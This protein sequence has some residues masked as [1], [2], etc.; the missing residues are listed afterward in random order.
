MTAMIDFLDK[1]NRK[2]R[3]FLIGMALGKRAFTLG[4]SFRQELC[5]AFRI[6][7]P[8]NA[9]V[10]MDYHLNCIHAAAALT[11]GNLPLDAPH[12][13]KDGSVDGTQE[14]VDLLVAFE[15]SSA[16]VHL[17]MLEAKGVT[18]FKDKQFKHKISRFKQIFGHT[19]N[20]WN[21]VK[22]YL[23]LIS[24]KKPENLNKFCPEWLKIN[25][26][27]AWLPMLIPEDRLVVFRCDPQ[28]RQNKEG[29]SWAVRGSL[30]W[31]SQRK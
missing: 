8:E 28:R 24:P 16:I 17:I 23:G 18:P 10:A 30:N 20:K 5:D 31:V 7:I 11:F 3:F 29:N 21:N 22:P 19:G 9:F 26:E 6:E 14:D 2:E 13:N 27:V 25:G 15:G 4:G 1:L 12:E